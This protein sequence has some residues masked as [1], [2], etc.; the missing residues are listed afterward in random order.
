MDPQHQPP[1]ARRCQALLIASA[2]AMA[3]LFG[4]LAGLRAWSAL[5]DVTSFLVHMALLFGLYGVACR[6][7]LGRRPGSGDQP[8]WEMRTTTVI[9]I[10][11]AVFRLL[12]LP[13]GLPGG[14]SDAG[15]LV[16]DL[17]G[18]AP[19]ET[20]LLYDN[21]VWRYLWD[22]R[23]TLSGIN[24]YGVS[25]QEVELSERPRLEALLEDSSWEEVHSR[26]GYTTYRTVYPPLAQGLFTL[27]AWVAPTS[28]VF[29]KLLMVL[30][31]LGACLLLAAWLHRWRRSPSW[32]VIYAWNPLVIKELAGSAHIDAAVVFFLLLAFQELSREHW[33]RAWAALAL[34]VLVKPAPVLLAPLFLRRGPWLRSWPF[35]L[36]GVAAWA[37]FAQATWTYL[38]SLKA[39]AADWAFNAGVWNA[40]LWSSGILGAEGRGWA[41]GVTTVLTLAWVAGIVY[42]QVDTKT[43]PADMG[44]ACFWVLAGYLVLSPT[45]MPWYLIWVL[46]WVAIRPSWAWPVLTA[47]CLLSYWI[48]VDGREATWPLMLEY[49][50]FGLAL[51]WDARRHSGRRRSA[52]AG[53]R[54]RTDAAP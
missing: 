50:L 47:A 1:D 9:V 19:F 2:L 48:Y 7:V 42:W 26:V 18:E 34:A 51:L 12:L 46:P 54:L 13:A 17:R 3:V 22:G 33:R 28:V 35:P 49:G 52:G 25:P 15:R 41:D 16:E 44:R 6:A 27:A 31:D 14:W 38:D 29:W 10:S 39:F 8:R 5:G 45:V 32:V 23:V 40:V 30:F 53:A 24:V 21:D 36:L 20:F 4:R 43:A 11:A 37:P